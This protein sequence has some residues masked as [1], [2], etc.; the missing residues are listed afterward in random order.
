MKERPILFSAPMVRALLAGTKT[1]TRRIVKPTPVADSRWAGGFYL[2]GKKSGPRAIA[3]EA[4]HI[5]TACPYGAPGDRLWVRETWAHS[6]HAMAAKSDEDGPFVY[7]ATHRVEQRL[8]EKWKPS[9]HM[10]RYACRLM[11]EITDVRVER[12]MSI[13]EEDARAEGIDFDPGEG[14]VFWVPGPGPGCASDTAA[15]SFRRL[16]ESINGDG[17]WN[18]NPFV[19]VVEF[20]RNGA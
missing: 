20:K 19:W 18:A 12:L 13:S 2:E 15:G 16:W 3:V 4:P 10:P 1:Q 11:L 8:G 5:A 14:G 7:A 6:I 9:I 17:S